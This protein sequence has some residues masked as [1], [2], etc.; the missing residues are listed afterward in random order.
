MDFSNLIHLLVKPQP[1]SPGD[2]LFWNDPY[3]S[4][5]MLKAHLDPD[6]DA[7]SRKPETIL[8]TINWLVDQVPLLPG[9][10]ILDLGCG[11]GL[12]DFHLAAQGFNV[13]GVDFSPGSIEF[14]RQTAAECGLKIDF[15]CQ[16]YLTLNDLDQYDAVLLIY[17]DYCVLPKNQRLQLLSAISRA[18]KK[19]GSFIF[20]VTTRSLRERI[21]LKNGWVAVKAGFWR[22]GPHLVLENGFDYPEL[23]VY[24]DQYIVIDANGTISTYRNWFQDFSPVSIRQELETAGFQILGM[25]G[26]LAGSEYTPESDWI[27]LITKPIIR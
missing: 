19:G 21:G 3:I 23:S 12:Y 16:D 14:A 4:S 7:A 26:D 22:P 11:P 5:Q 25:W 10:S 2:S 13:T 18:L 17:G 24:L 8:Q 6:T 9:Q 1:F 15:R 20:D 27:G